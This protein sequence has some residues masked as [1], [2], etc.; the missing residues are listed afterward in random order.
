MKKSNSPDRTSL[1]NIVLAIFGFAVVFFLSCAEAPIMEFPSEVPSSTSVGEIKNYCVYSEAR[2]CYS[3]YYSGCPAGGELSDICP[4]NSSS[5]VVASS[6]SLVAGGS[7][8][9][10]GG[11][12]SSSALLYEYCVFVSD[13]M[14]LTGPMSSC[15][16]G[17]ALSNSCPYGSSSSAV[18]SSSS[19]APSSSSATPSSSSLAQSSSS[20]TPS[21]SSLVPSSSSRASSSSV[22]Q[23]SSSAT[24]SSSSIQSGVVYG[25]SVTYEGETYETVV[26]GTQTWFK[27]NLN[28][29][30]SGSKCYADSTANCTK[31]GR[32]YN[33][34]TA[35]TVCPSGWHLPSYD[36]W[37]MLKS[38]IE[39]DKGC[40]SCD[41]K[42][43]KAKIGWANNGNGQDTYGFSALPG[44]NGNSNGGFAA[45]G[46]YGYWWS[47]SESTSSNA[48]RL[49][50]YCNYDYAGWLNNGNS[51]LFSVR[52][53]QD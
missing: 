6:S 14:C 39:T 28:Y 3:G 51:S 4:F 19:I 42:H 16:P 47:A 44:G 23:S 50:M 18:A 25:P 37:G 15:L 27:R 24:P 12:S 53:L 40:T 20:A 17:G 34:A 21:S 31:Y 30:A 41:A 43:L 38:Y 7:S 2:Q 11:Q 35:K 13:K 45:V 36:E 49:Y 8:S 52:C 10:Q 29:D 46:G 33:W 22:A 1:A 26:I 9:S 48:Y 5:S 32:L